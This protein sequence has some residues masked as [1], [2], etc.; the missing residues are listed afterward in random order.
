[1][2]DTPKTLAEIRSDACNTILVAITALAIPAAGASLLRGLEQG[3]L[4]VMGVHVALAALLLWATLLRR[5]LNYSFRATIVT[6]VPF[7]IAVGGLLA[8]GRGN[9]ALMFFVSSCVVA[10]CFFNRRTALAVVAL[11]LVTLTTIYLG[12]RLNL[13]DLPM[14]PTIYDMSALS[15]F[16]LGLA[17]LAAGAAPLIGLSAV[18]QSLE[19]ERRRADEAVKIRSDFLAH[20]S[21][22]LR[23]PMAGLMGMAEAL[24]GTRLDVQQQTFVGNLMHAGRNLLAVLNDLLDF[25]KFE[26]GAIPLERRPFNISEMVGSTC[27]LFEARARLKG[28]AV[29]IQLP[30][31][32][33]NRV[34]GDSHRIS[35]VLSNVIDNAIKFTDHGTVTVSVR[36]IQR[37]DGRLTM[38]CT[39]SDTGIGLSESE[40]AHVFEPFIQ[41]DNSISRKYGGSGLG[42]AICRKLLD[43]MDGEVSVVSRPGHGAAFTIKIPLASGGAEHR[44]SHENVQT[45]D[46][47][48]APHQRRDDTLR[49]LVA[50]DDANMQLLIDIMLPRLGHAVTV[51]RDGAAAVAAAGANAYDCIIMD[52]HMPVMNGPEAM[53]RIH[54]AERAMG[55]RTPMIALTADLIPEHVHTFL[56]AGA[57]AVVGKPVDWDTLE[58]KIRQLS[59]DRVPAGAL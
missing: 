59:A 47:P 24:K 37:D 52:M 20:M 17:F 31:H 58:A 1:M 25:S 33:Q 2:G 8:Y 7:I 18:L 27:A 48:P 12:Y 3:W 40:V 49:L 46:T 32:L 21:H 51:V 15:W 11:C 34:I 44:I 23:T 19:T 54:E 10:G 9:G 45:A 57:D 42:L 13:I 5:R 14:S 29:V 4:P 28:L 39:V 6:A 26:A 50:E 16:A 53:R 22:E 38:E 35:H 43:A 30:S 55:R 56:E 36:Q 41:A